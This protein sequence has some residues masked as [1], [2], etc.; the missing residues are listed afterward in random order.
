MGSPTFF[1]LTRAVCR[2]FLW[3]C[4]RWEVTGREHVPAEGAV[5][6]VANHIS[7]LD[8]PA[9]GA[10]IRRPVHFMAKEEL[11][12]FPLLGRLMPHMLAFPVRRGTADRQAL[13]TA[14]SLLAA[15]EVVA[16]FPEG[17]R[18]RG[19][20]LGPPELGAALLAL[21]TGAWVV[22][23]AVT[24]TERAL[25]YGSPV[26]RCAKVR[27][28]FGPA[29]RFGE[30]KAGRTDRA[31]LERAGEEIMSAIAA[32]LDLEATRDGA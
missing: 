32:L 1:Y 22:P 18:Q 17:R 28:R 15:G 2:A 12:R 31:E 11:F 8:P 20:R 26:P 9:V 10:A 24:G 29:L 25:P 4:C 16:V 23:A 21:R 14:Q 19:E 30:G 7:Y 5:I 3:A 6:V 27:L 13:R